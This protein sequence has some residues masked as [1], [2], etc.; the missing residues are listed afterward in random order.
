VLYPWRA[1]PLL[2]S[3]PLRKIPGIGS[4]TIH[5]LNPCLMLAAQQQHGRQPQQLPAFWTCRDLLQ[6]PH[7]EAT[8]C[9]QTMQAYE[10]SA[11]EHCHV[12]F[13][14]CRGLDDSPVVD[15]QGGLPKTV[16]VENSFKRGTILTQRA[17]ND[18]MEDLYERLPRLLKERA[19][20]SQIPGKAYPTTIRVT[21][22][23]VEKTGS[24]SSSMRQ[25]ANPQK[26]RR[27][28]FVTH[29]KQMTVDG[30]TFMA[31]E[32]DVNGKRDF[33]RRMVAPL[34]RTLLPN[35]DQI[36]VT[37]INIATTNFQDLLL[38]PTPHATVRQSKCMSMTQSPACLDGSPNVSGATKAA[39]ATA[40]VTNDVPSSRRESIISPSKRPFQLSKLRQQADS[41]PLVVDPAVL[42]ELPA[43]I[44]AEVR[45][46]YPQMKVASK[47]KRIDQFFAP[48]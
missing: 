31:L 20:W 36:N 16:S 29:S 19:L 33:L 23:S 11:A 24:S 3:M 42:A 18:A 14:K 35:A 44:A 26:T 9:L 2:A 12:M 28:P 39:A 47:R 45:R 5:A 21:V 34:V 38:A 17:V 4:R 48:K 15:D 41:E 40:T 7:A 22:R 37:R 6:I 27:R 8:E 10:K 43:D 25:L 13:Q 30:Q 46:A 1:P 32:D